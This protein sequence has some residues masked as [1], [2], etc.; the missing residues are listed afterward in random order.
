LKKFKN[1]KKDKAG[2]T[3]KED[4]GMKRIVALM[5][6]LGLV[7]TA[8]MGCG[9]ESSSE[10]GT[11][12]TE[13]KEETA[14]T[15]G[16]ED[17]ASEA[18][19]GDNA[20]GEFTFGFITLADSDVWCKSVCTAFEKY[21]SETYPGCKVVTADGNCDANLQIQAVENFI[22]QQV[23]VIVI[24]PADADAAGPG[25]EAANAANI[26]VICSAIKSNSGEY[27]YVGPENLEAGK[28]HAEYVMEHCEPGVKVL[29]LQGT[30]G[31]NHSTDRYNGFINTLDEANF[32]YELLSAQDA[33]YLRTEG[34]R[35]MEDWIQKYPAFDVVV[36]AN[37]QMA[38]G[39]IE[40][41]KA[42]NIDGTMVLGLDATDDAR[43]EIKEGYMAGSLK[44]DAVAIG[45]ASADCS[46]RT[47]SGEQ[48][49]DE[50]V[51]FVM[52]AKDNVDTE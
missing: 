30:A 27:T 37:D 25:V 20:D 22:A 18:Q 15:V 39:A 8:L 13:V 38:L 42:A 12:N 2:C 26:P 43:V 9:S 24:Q 40:A 11:N 3:K 33:N 4:F 35:I 32:E 51:P 16:A 45:Q 29:Y 48:I 10:S 23:D 36:A 1:L 7:S 31:L 46:F 19:A 28:M 17:T 6:A 44:Q 52:I 47:A 49:Q 5:L 50:Y 34:L 41:L 21:V 14:D